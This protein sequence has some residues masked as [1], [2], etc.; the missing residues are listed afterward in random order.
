MTNKRY[1]ICYEF[2]TTAENRETAEKMR[3]DITRLLV[4]K[5]PQIYSSHAWIEEVEEE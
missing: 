3:S 4:S 2:G 5:F 1:C